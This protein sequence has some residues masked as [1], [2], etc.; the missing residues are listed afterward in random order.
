MATLRATGERVIDAPAGAVYRIIADYHVGH[1]A[2]LPRQFFPSLEVEEGG[3]GA[4]TRVRFAVRAFG[5]TREVRARIEEPE[6][7]RVLLERVI[8][9]RSTVTRFIV[10]P[11]G[12]DRCRVTIVTEW[13]SHGVRAWVERLLAPRMLRRMYDAELETL[14]AYAAAQPCPAPAADPPRPTG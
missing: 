7:G 13:T 4:G 5:Q 11:R 6:P 9:E 2:I 1:P 3:T 10:D 12:P 14:A 8:D